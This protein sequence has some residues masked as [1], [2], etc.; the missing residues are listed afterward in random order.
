METPDDDERVKTQFPPKPKPH[1]NVGVIGGGGRS[2]M[3]LLMAMTAA[4]SMSGGIVIPPAKPKP[5][6][7]EVV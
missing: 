6:E 3:A 7:D 4:M 1:L 2:H 5:S